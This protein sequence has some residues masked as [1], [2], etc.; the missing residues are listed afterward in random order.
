LHTALSGYWALHSK[1]IPR[2]SLPSLVFAVE[3][4]PGRVLVDIATDIGEVVSISDDVIVETA[5]PHGA[6]E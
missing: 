2:S 5:L 4:P 6:S 3:F 1:R